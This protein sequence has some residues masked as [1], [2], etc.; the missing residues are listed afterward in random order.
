MKRNTTELITNACVCKTDTYKMSEAEGC[1]VAEKAVRTLQEF[2]EITVKHM[3]LLRVSVMISHASMYVTHVSLWVVF[4]IWLIFMPLAPYPTPP[5]PSSPL[6]PPE[7]SL[8]L[9]F[10]SFLPIVMV[11]FSGLVVAYIQFL[12]TSFPHLLFYSPQR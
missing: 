4:L 5:P 7:M 10:F 11:V 1:C 2:N 3:M 9:S 12:K 8:F 6:F